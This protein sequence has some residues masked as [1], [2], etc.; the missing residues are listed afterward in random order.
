M[1]DPQPLRRDAERNRQRIL[2]EAR[3]L[4]A[5]QGLTPSH[6]DIARAAGVGVG[7]VYR[8]F[9]QKED[10]LAALFEEQVETVVTLAGAAL[11][12]SDPWQ[13]LHD[14]LHRTARMQA[15]DRGL[16]ELLTGT[17]S[18]SALA[19]SATARIAPV[20]ARLVAAAQATGQMRADVTVADVALVPLMVGA[21]LDRSRDVR[22]DLWQRTLALVLDGFRAEGARPL[23][24]PGVG[25]EQFSRILGGDG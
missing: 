13:A 24:T 21:V 15:A 17:G 7:T 3:R 11:R 22:P 14:F 20:I 16:K 2:D 8:R 25:P 4:F 9:P 6:D 5:Q 23:P 12:E 10:L 1:A 18:P 19:R